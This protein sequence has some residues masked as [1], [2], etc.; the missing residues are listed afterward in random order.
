MQCV[1]FFRSTLSRLA[2][3]SVDTRAATLRLSVRTGDGKTLSA[4]SN[5]DS[6]IRSQVLRSKGVKIAYF[7][8]WSCTYPGLRVCANARINQYEPPSFRVALGIQAQVGA[9]QL[10]ALVVPRRDNPLLTGRGHLTVI[11]VTG[12]QCDRRSAVGI[13]NLRMGPGE[14]MSQGLVRALTVKHWPLLD[15]WWTC[16]AFAD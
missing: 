2:H 5:G 6:V 14:S 11:A 7:D 3:L 8:I 9:V 1:R 13:S 15:S 10:N 16:A 12:R 4:A